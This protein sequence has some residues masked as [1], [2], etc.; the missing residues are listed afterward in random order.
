M[1]GGK[2]KEGLQGRGFLAR[3][4]TGIVSLGSQAERERDRR[5]NDRNNDKKMINAKEGNISK[6]REEL[7][8]CANQKN[9]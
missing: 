8:I 5:R 9:R 2:A 1:V 4:G 3:I 7:F 6:R